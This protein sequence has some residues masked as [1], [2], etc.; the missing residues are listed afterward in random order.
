M[1]GKI[2]T[3]SKMDTQSHLTT[4]LKQIDIKTGY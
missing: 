1:T 2:E 4:G 3:N